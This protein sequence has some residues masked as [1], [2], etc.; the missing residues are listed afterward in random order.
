MSEQDQDGRTLAATD[1]RTVAVRPSVNPLVARGLADLSN[2]VQ[3]PDTLPQADSRTRGVMM[4]MIHN[5][6]KRLLAKHGQ[7]PTIEEIA[8]ETGF[9]I[10]D[11]VRIQKQ[12]FADPTFCNCQPGL[13]KALKQASYRQREVLKLL[14][15][16]GDGYHYSYEEVSHIFKEPREIIQQAERGAALKVLEYFE[17]TTCPNT[18]PPFLRD[19]PTSSA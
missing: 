13:L 18:G 15:G 14:Y 11:I 8:K 10:N 9:T 17:N 4:S 3:Q 2:A 16:V 5:A 6:A 19:T 1:N 7:A 12:F